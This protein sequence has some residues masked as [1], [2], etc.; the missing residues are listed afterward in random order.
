MKWK[1][2]V[3]AVKQIGP[4]GVS[5]RTKAALLLIDCRI[6]P[7]FPSGTVARLWQMEAD[8]TPEQKKGPQN[9]S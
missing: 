3:G 1:R 6:S 2:E 5:E 8:W 7:T 4:M 9:L